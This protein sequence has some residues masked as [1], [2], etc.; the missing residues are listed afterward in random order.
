MNLIDLIGTHLLRSSFW[1]KPSTY[2]YALL[3][4]LDPVTEVAVAGYHRINLTPSDANWTGPTLNNGN[5]TNAKPVQFPSIDATVVGWGIVIDN[6]F[7]LTRAFATPVVCTTETAGPYFSAGALQFQ[8]TSNSNYPKLQPGTHLLRTASWSKP[9][10]IYVALFSV[11]PNA[12][13]T[14][15]TEV[16]GG[17]YPRVQHGPGDT[18]WDEP[19]VDGE[20]VNLGTITFSNLPNFSTTIV[21]FGLYDAATSGTYLEGN[22]FTPSI[23]ID[24]GSPPLTFG[25]GKLM[26]SITV[27]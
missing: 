19:T 15:G 11:M 1:S 9:A 12:A 26:V 2:Q 13:G 23:S 25:A 14:G 7:I 16:T 3:S 22:V 20:I 24:S 10:A 18:Y 21:G 27:S 5:F 17:V 6:F 4:S 8:F